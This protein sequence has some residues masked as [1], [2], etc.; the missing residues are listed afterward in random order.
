M[1][2]ARMPA[3]CSLAL[4][5]GPLRPTF[6]NAPNSRVRRHGVLIGG[7]RLC[8]GDGPCRSRETGGRTQAAKCLSRPCSRWRRNTPA[9]T[10]DTRQAGAAFPRTLFRWALCENV[11]RKRLSVNYQRSTTFMTFCAAR[12]K[13]AGDQY[14]GNNQNRQNG[15]TE[16]ITRGAGP[17]H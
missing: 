9:L 13:S 2:V 15:Q 4:G 12:T 17:S 1:P 3:S 14:S 10:S 11:H 7:W 5:A 6:S 8:N 16:K